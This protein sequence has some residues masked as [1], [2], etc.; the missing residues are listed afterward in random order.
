MPV[1]L[2]TKHIIVLLLGCCFQLTSGYAQYQFENYSVVNG[3]SDN[4]V[5]C[6]FKDRTGFMWIGTENGLNRFDGHSFLL[7]YP[8]QQKHQISNPYINDIEQ[9]DKNR[10]WVATYNGLNVLDTKTDSLYVFVPEDD[11][12]RQK[13]KSV[14]SNLV[15]DMYIDN[16]NRVWM[17]ADMRDL[18]YYDIQQKRFVYFPWKG[19]IKKHFP[20]RENSYNSIRKIYPKSN[21]ELWLGT[22]VGLFSFTISTGTFHY[23]ASKQVD[24]FIQLQSSPDKQTV[25]FI[26]SPGNTLQMHSVESGVTKE[27]PWNTISTEQPVQHT[28]AIRWLPAGKDILEINTGTHEVKRIQHETDNPYSLPAGII[29]TIYQENTGLVWIGTSEGFAKFNPNLNLFH[30]SAILP[31]NKDSIDIEEDLFRTNLNI[32]TVFYSKTDNRYYISSPA[33]NCLFI[34]NAAT[35]AKETIS[36]VN[37]IPLKKCSV[38]YE[39]SKGILWILTTTYAF[40]YDRATKKFTTS[41]FVCGPKTTLCTDITEDADGN[42]WIACHNSGV[43]FYSPATG[44]TTLLPVPKAQYTSLPTSLYLDKRNNQLWIGTFNTGLCRYDVSTKKIHYFIQSNKPGYMHASLV[45]DITAGKNGKVWIATYAGGVAVCKTDTRDDQFTHITSNN[46]LPENNVHSLITDSKGNIWGTTHTSLFSMDDNGKNLERYNRNSGLAFT[47]FSSPLTIASDGRIFTGVKDGF[48]SFMPDSL[49]YHSSPFSVVLTS[50]K[51]KNTG[52]LNTDSI[53]SIVKMDHDNNEVEFGFAALSYYQPLQT[54]YEYQLEGLDKQWKSNGNNTQVKYNNLAP[55]TYRFK[56]RAIDFTGRPSG[57]EA[58]LS[59]KILPP[60]W[61]TWWFLLLAATTLITTGILLYRRRIAVI[62]NKAAMQLQLME[63]KEQA[64]RSQMNPHFI[65]NSLNAIQ[66]LVVT[67]NYTAGYEYLSKFSKLMRMV[68]NLSEKNLIPL[69][70]EI[71]MCQLYL[72]LE[73]LRFKKSFRYHLECDEQMDTDNILFPTLLLQPFLEN[74]IWHGLMQ[75]QGEKQVFVSFEEKE[76]TLT[77]TIFDNGIG[78]EKAAAIKAS[79]IGSAYVESK[80]IQLAQQRIHTLKA[81]G[82]GNGNITI[83]DCKDDA[84]NAAGTKVYISI[85]SPM[86]KQ[87]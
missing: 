57:N 11:A 85:Y 21:D 37:G 2:Y 59:F 86:K 35:G 38:I 29:K 54:R 44:E 63:L 64:L 77:C 72:E 52:E 79:K 83:I 24:H 80:A 62:K 36:Q 17:A 26:Q 47:G 15:W 56:V 49:T 1:L 61:N 65:F 20:G 81:A 9:D 13:E 30:Y 87:S 66:E 5:T 50:F 4:R 34:V 16:A 31:R 53:S 51:T 67:E 19:Y 76:D 32:H 58:G 60:W 3:L 84:G 39:D 33:N 10:L 73:S 45:T 6:F 7:Y 25:Y 12:Y 82:L 69:S 46:G 23:H 70:S 75:K 22:A 14:P 40:Q 27:I 41:S 74:A 43:Y 18:C 71:E 68:L 55:G 42:F 28:N 48:I 8:G 78:R